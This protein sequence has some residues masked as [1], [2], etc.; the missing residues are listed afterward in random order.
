MDIEEV[1]RGVMSRQQCGRGSDTDG[2]DLLYAGPV[3][4]AGP[5]HSTALME[6]GERCRLGR[7]WIEKKA[8]THGGPGRL[9]VGL[10][11]KMYSWRLS[12]GTVPT[13]K[14]NGIILRDP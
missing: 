6:Q 1:R 9:G 14:V 7:G 2:R 3:Q 13:D 11:A 12:H 5:L 10:Q 4:H 8:E